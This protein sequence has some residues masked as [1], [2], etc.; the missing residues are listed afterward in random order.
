MK[1]LICL[2]IVFAV[3]VIP[4]VVITLEAQPLSLSTNL[5]AEDLKS[6]VSNTAVAVKL[7][8]A[9][10]WKKFLMVYWWLSALLLV[11]VARFIIL[12]TPSK[13]DDRFFF[14]WIIRPLRFIAKVFS[15]SFKK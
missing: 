3:F 5:S 4:A 12:I 9:I 14:K 2:L 7:I 6:A 10:G 11:G 15:L 1:K 8:K 13:E